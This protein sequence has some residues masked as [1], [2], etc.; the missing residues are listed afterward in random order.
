MIRHK[1]LQ[2]TSK[3]SYYV[4]LLNED[5]IPADELQKLTYLLCHDYQRCSKSVSVPAPVYHAHHAAVRGKS[6]YLA[7][8]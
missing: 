5:K 3:P 7:V 2:G 8:M 6:N 4:V 1:I